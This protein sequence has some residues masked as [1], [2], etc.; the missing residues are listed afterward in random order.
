MKIYKYP[1]ELVPEQEIE[2]PFRANILTVQIQNDTPC[3]WALVDTE[4]IRV[5]KRT[6]HIRG[7]GH[8][9]NVEAFRYISTFQQLNGGLIWHVFEEA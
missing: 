6:I 9:F 1:L 3:L 5:A 8:E 7:T 4:E 2:M